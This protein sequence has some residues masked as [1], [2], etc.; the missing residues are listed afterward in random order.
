M[1][2]GSGGHNSKLNASYTGGKR[3]GLLEKHSTSVQVA[4][5]AAGSSVAQGSK[6][7]TKN[8]SNSQFMP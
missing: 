2:L 1:V 5:T 4:S 3:E 6:G 7:L 8:S